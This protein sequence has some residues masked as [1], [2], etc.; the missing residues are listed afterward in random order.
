MGNNTD[1]RRF[2][3]IYK[4]ER[5]NFWSRKD[6]KVLQDGKAYCH[7]C[8]REMEPSR[9]KVRPIASQREIA[10]R[11]F[12]GRYASPKSCRARKEDDEGYD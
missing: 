12:G 3:K 4:C 8:G 1:G 6:W 9:K 5:C 2:E 10:A 7:N 11:F